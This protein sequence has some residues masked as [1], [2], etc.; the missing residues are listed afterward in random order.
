MNFTCIC[1][2]ASLINELCNC[3]YLSSALNAIF[4]IRIIRGMPE[5]L[6]VVLLFSPYIDA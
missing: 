4:L 2:R 6:S 3:L 1:K 5:S